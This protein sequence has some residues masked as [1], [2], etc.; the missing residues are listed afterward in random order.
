[1]ARYS[2]SQPQNDREQRPRLLA[3]IPFQFPSSVLFDS[4]VLLSKRWFLKLFNPWTLA[5]IMSYLTDYLAEK[6]D[7]LNKH[8]KHRKQAAN[9]QGDIP[10]VQKANTSIIIPGYLQ[11]DISINNANLRSAFNLY[12]KWVLIFTFNINF[13][14]L[15]V[16]IEIKWRTIDFPTGFLASILFASTRQSKF[17]VTSKGT[18]PMDNANLCSTFNCY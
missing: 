7:R 16:A 6:H 17:L 12:L 14:G 10:M 9:P 15:M 3:M 5:N 2:S 4:L 8:C 13:V 11:R 18:S 1:M